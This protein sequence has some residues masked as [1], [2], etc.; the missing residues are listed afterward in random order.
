[1]S[2]QNSVPSAALHVAVA[3][4]DNDNIQQLLCL[5][6]FKNVRKSGRR[7]MISDRLP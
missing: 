7:S 6:V 4:H 1:V 5:T 3:T 2:V